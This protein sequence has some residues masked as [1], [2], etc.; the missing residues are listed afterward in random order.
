LA[1]RRAGGSATYLSGRVLQ[2]WYGGSKRLELA[3]FAARE[4]V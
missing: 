3:A 1:S 4:F 2:S